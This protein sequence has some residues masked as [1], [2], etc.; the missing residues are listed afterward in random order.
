MEKEA[1]LLVSS[2]TQANLISLISN[3][4]R[5]NLVILEEQSHIYWYEVGGIS[6]IA[7]LQPWPVKSS[8]GA[9]DPLDIED[10]IK[11]KDIH[12]ADPA[13]ICIENTHNRHGGT[14]ITPEQIKKISEVAHSHELRLY[15]DGARIF[16]AAVA[17]KKNVKKYLNL[18]G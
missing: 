18:C 1:A 4:K 9:F 8:F 10:A 15:M 7:G 12:F 6:S 2:G 17:L 14:I 13:L 3:T 5:G 16:N 11:Q